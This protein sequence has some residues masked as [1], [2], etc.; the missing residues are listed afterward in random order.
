MGHPILHTKKT[1]IATIFS[2]H[3]NCVNSNQNYFGPNFGER[4]LKYK[5]SIVLEE[6]CE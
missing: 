5:I 4:A 6:K 2:K 1:Q 3:W